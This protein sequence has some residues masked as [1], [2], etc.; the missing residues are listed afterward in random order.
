M[1]NLDYISGFVI[2]AN[3]INPLSRGAEFRLA[4]NSGCVHEVRTSLF[5]VNLASNSTCD[6]PPAFSHHIR[7]AQT[8]PLEW[9]LFF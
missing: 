5:T 3:I 2:N 9:G 6:T 7:D 8:P 4:R 1:K